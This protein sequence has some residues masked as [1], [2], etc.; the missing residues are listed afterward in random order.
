MTNPLLHTDGLPGFDRIRPEHVSPAIDELLTE[1]DA[2][3]ERAVGAEVP[4][5]YDA[6]SAVLDVATER[7]GRA[8]GAVSHLNAVADTPELRAAYNDNLPKVTDFHTR[9]GADERLYAKYKAIATS[10]AAASLPAPRRKALAN[11]VRDFVLSGAELTGDAKKRFAQIQER[12]AELS[13]KFSEH[14][15]DAT[16]GWSYFARPEELDGVPQDVKQATRAAAQVEGKDGHKLTLHYPVY[17]PVMQYGADRALRER[18]HTAFVT[19]A[20]DLGPAERDNSGLMRELLALRQE[21]AKLL[22]YRSYA[23]VSL[24]PKMA[25]SPQQVLDFLRDLARRA[26]PYAER[27][28]ADLREFAARDLSLPDMRAWDLAYASERLK[29]ERY[30]FSD[31]EVKCYFTEPKVLA[32]LFSIVETLFEVSIRPDAAPTWNE[33]VRFYRIERGKTL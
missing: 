31:Q 21:E 3:L 8:W 30:A 1:A 23:E 11:A 13:Q 29:E 17:L 5:D 22:G 14:V 15:L 24:V 10:P 2:A 16:D 19:R 28:L 6:M 32:G 7:F 12:L 18:L 4:A 26:R 25:D 9:L 27:D 20:S 33:A